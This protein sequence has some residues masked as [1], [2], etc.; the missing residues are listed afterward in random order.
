[1]LI[2]CILCF[3]ADIAKSEL[4]KFINAYKSASGRLLKGISLNQGRDFW[5]RQVEELEVSAS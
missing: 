1:M 4:S 2:M 5:G 3:Q